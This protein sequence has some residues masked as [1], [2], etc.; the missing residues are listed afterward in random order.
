MRDETAIFCHIPK[1]AGTTL[2]RIIER[3]YRP[4]MRHYIYHHDA[5][6]EAF[7]ALPTAR[8]AALRM[9]RGHIPFGIHQYLPGPARYFT[10]LRQPIERIISYYYFVQREPDHYLYDYSNTPGMTL[11]RYLEDQVSLQTDNYQTRLISGVWTDVGY[12]ECD[13]SVLELAKEN[14]AEHFAVV[15]LTKWF[16]QTLLLLQRTFGWNNIFYMRHNVTRGRP[17]R[18]ALP[19]ETLDVIAAHNQLDLELYAFGAKLFRQQ[20][21]DQG[22]SFADAIKRFQI[23]NRRIQPLLRAYWTV[24]TVSVRTWLRNLRG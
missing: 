17:K 23:A 8:R 20:V 3:Q 18:E 1:T 7:K 22:P 9:V 19:P 16:D 13:R 12:G 10:I 11:R 14:L 21:Q 15:G 6:V 24:R 2:Q 4:K 5:G